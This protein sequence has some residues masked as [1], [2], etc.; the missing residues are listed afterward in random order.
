M[1]FPTYNVEFKRASNEEFIVASGEIRNDSNRDYTCGL[2]KIILYGK[3]SAIG[4]GIIKI[5]DFKVKSTK[6][7]SILVEAHSRLIPSILRYEIIMERGY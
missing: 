2:F 7:F 4:T 6:A 5:Y 1:I 3:H